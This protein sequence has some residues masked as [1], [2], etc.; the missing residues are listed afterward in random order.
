MAD[1]AHRR[2]PG[3]PPRDRATAAARRAQ[4][5]QVA[6]GV[7]ARRGYRAADVQEIADAA[8]VG[9]AT[10][11]RH[12]PSKRQ[13]FVAALERGVMQL[14]DTVHA[15]TALP[16]QPLTG[17]ARAVLAYLTFLDEH[18]ELVELLIQEQAEQCAGAISRCVERRSLAKQQACALFKPL[19]RR[20]LMRP[21]PPERMADM[22]F[23]LMYG[24]MYFN[25]VIGRHK[26]LREQADD[27]LDI[28]FHGVLSPVGRA[29]LARSLRAGRASQHRESR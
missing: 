21:V 10:I 9:K 24:T 6:A 22:I 1:T 13:L 25:H 16:D 11:Y 17:I 8:R 15:A 12:F 23:N 27:L 26:P 3:R 18:P 4:Y 19:I 7:F 28:F 20:G 29:Q 2:R 5:L 14:H